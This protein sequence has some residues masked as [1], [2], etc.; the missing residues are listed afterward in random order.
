M[1]IDVRT[2]A[3][4]VAAV[5][6]GIVH[7]VLGYFYLVSGLVVPFYALL[8]LWVW[9]LFLAAMLVRLAVRRSWWAVAVPVVAFVTWV[10]VLVFGDFVLGWTA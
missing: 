10:L 1:P 7:L 6:A 2:T 8:P 3:P 9:W 5:L 4:L